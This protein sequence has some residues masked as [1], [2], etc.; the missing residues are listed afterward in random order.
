LDLDHLDLSKNQLNGSI[1]PSFGSLIYLQTLDISSN[2]LT[3]EVPSS[4]GSIIDENKGTLKILKLSFN[5][6]S[7]DI[8]SSLGDLADLQTLDLSFN[9]LSGTI[10]SSLRGKK[11]LHLSLQNNQLS[12]SIPSSLGNNP[13]LLFLSLENNLLVGLIPSSLVSLSSIKELHVSNNSLSGPVPELSSTIIL[14]ELSNNTDLCGHP[15]ISNICTDGLITCNMDC[16]MM[17]AWLPKMFDDS[18]CCSQPGIGCFNERITNLYVYFKAYSI[19]EL[20]LLMDS[21]V[22][23]LKRLENLLISLGL[24]S[25]A[26]ISPER[27]SRRL[28][29]SIASSILA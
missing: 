5:K 8:P 3:G 27:F 12:G 16:R 2:Q 17:N 10:P 22:R 28:R 1:P 23:Y 6:L 14:C 15:E 21:M 20:W 19:L 29:I 25:I 24:T 13:N 18:N 4:L 9:L 7:G 11:M 26:T